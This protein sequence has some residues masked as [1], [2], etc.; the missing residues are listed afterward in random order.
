MST[1]YSKDLGDGVEAYAPTQEIMNLF[2]AFFVAAK[3]PKDMAIF[4]AYPSKTNVV[5]VYLTPACGAVATAIGAK[6]CDKPRRDE[7]SDLGLLIGHSDA[8]KVFFPS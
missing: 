6:P 7:G 2:Q 8:W 4:S 1:W 3:L 5:T